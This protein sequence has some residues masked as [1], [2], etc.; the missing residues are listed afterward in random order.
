[1]RLLL[2][3]IV[4]FLAALQESQLAKYYRRCLRRQSRAHA[5]SLQM[6]RESGI[7]AIRTAGRLYMTRRAAECAIRDHQR[8]HRIRHIL[9]IQEHYPHHHMLLS[10]NELYAL[11]A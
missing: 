3:I 6:R 4:T 2:N 8:I 10:S 9:G 5:L 11:Y 1:M 7:P